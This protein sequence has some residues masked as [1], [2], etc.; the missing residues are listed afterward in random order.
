MEITKDVMYKF[1]KDDLEIEEASNVEFQRVHRIGKKKVG[2]VRPII[3]RFLKYPDREF[4]FKRMC[5]GI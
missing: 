2:E 5:T 4:I 1:F 3:A